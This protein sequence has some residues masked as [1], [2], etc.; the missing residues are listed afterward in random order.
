MPPKT[1]LWK[2]EDHTLGK[3]RVLKNY[4]PEFGVKERLIK[5]VE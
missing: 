5:L 2:L 3:H 4:I 1:T